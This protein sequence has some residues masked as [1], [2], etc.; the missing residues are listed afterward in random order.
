MVKCK[1]FDVGY[2]DHGCMVMLGC[3]VDDEGYEYHGLSQYVINIDYIKRILDAIGV[4][5]VTGI[6][7]KSCWIDGN[8]PVA[9]IIKIEVVRP[10]HKKEGTPFV[11]ADWRKETRKKIEEKSE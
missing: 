9:G 10:L 6:N 11:I 4:S 7:R 8:F 2:E 3:F 5:R 1:G